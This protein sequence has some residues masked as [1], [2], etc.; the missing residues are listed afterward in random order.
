MRLLAVTWV[1][2]C[3]W[4]L[5]TGFVLADFSGFFLLVIAGVFVSAALALKKRGF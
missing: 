4:A 3:L 5:L 2:I 1:T